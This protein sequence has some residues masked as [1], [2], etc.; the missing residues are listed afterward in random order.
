[1]KT[2]V[3]VGCT[4]SRAQ[5]NS[6]RRSWCSLFE[7]WYVIFHNH[8]TWRVIFLLDFRDWWISFETRRTDI[9]EKQ[10][11]LTSFPGPFFVLGVG[12]KD[13]AVSGESTRLPTMW[14]GFKSR[15]Q[16]HMWVLSLLLVLSFAPRGFSPGTSAFPC[17][18]QKPTFS[19]S[20]ST[21]ISGRQRSHFVD[22]LPLNH[23]IFL[24]IIIFI[25]SSTSDL[26]SISTALWV[27]PDKRLFEGET[28]AHFPNSGW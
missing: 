27:I 7:E 3:W 2:R 28:W 17:P 26:D 1:M 10:K 18:S 8:S 21:R 9:N 4:V 19:N 15:R 22:V 16:H 25:C 24:F 20:N 23:Y 6:T 11:F 14:P 5:Q 13:G 12:G